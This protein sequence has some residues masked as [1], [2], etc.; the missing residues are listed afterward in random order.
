M[1]QEICLRVQ[2]LPP[3]TYEVA[4]KPGDPTKVTSLVRAASKAA[5]RSSAPRSH[6]LDLSALAV[7]GRRSNSKVN[8]PKANTEE[9]E[10]LKAERKVQRPG[11]A[12]RQG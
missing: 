9:K 3:A 1:N 10:K 12:A 5:F 4:A 7:R 2:G 8:R 6:V 11:L